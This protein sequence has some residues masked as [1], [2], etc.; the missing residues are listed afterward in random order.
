[1][2]HFDT[3]LTKILEEI[4]DLK[5]KEASRA[6]ERTLLALIGGWVVALFGV[7]GSAAGAIGVWHDWGEK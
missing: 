5:S 6:A 4:G 1:M 2:D 7:I 3:Q